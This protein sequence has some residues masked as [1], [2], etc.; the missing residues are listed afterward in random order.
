MSSPAGAA[1]LGVLVVVLAL[2]VG[3]LLAVLRSR[4]RR[5]VAGPETGPAVDA[6]VA[7]RPFAA[8]VANPTKVDDP[9][10]RLDW[11]RGASEELGW[12][13]PL[14]LETTRE[15]N[16]AGQA[17]SAAEAGASVVLAYG[18]DG[19][20][21]AVASALT[22][23]GVPLA[24]LPAG[25]GNLLARNLGIGV[26]D[27]STAL[28]TAL[29]W[30][31]RKIDVGR[32]EIDVSGEDHTP[33]R[34]TFLVMAGLGFDAEV[35][36]TVE[37]R[38]KERVG[39]FAYVLTGLQLVRGRRSKVVLRMDDR[40]PLTRRMRSVVVGNC[41]ELTGGVR[42]LPDAQ[43]DDGWLDV[44]VVSAGG[45]VGWAAVI[46]AVLT[47]S[48]RGHP[49]VEHFRCREI[50]VRAEAPHH[51]QIDGDPAGEAR[52]LRAKVDPLAL[53]VRV[54]PLG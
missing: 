45:V 11:V 4:A 7:E 48:R 5:P 8:V 12:A 14:W 9:Q 44:V 50:E 49:V 53:S 42:L 3:L 33:A 47:R 27:L 28:R 15:D 36:A 13:P 46:G 17:R 38:L 51:V 19:T 2:A 37:P 18:G 31:E 26:T 16:G 20:V 34:E 39:W 10:V 32:C 35:M 1:Q 40:P 6:A 21:R 24:L 25:T 23:T 30:S 22:G 54:P 41:G 29:G 43:V 52:V